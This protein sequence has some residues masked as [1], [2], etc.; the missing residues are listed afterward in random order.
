MFDAPIVTVDEERSQSWARLAICLVALVGFGVIVRTSDSVQPATVGPGFATILAYLTFGVIWHAFLTRYPRRFPLR[1]YVAMTADIGIMV[2]WMHLGGPFVTAY[3]PIFLWVIIG[4]GIRF[5]PRFLTIGLVMGAMGMGSLLVFNEY[6]VGHLSLGLGLLLGV[7]VLPVFFLTVLRRLQTVGRLE[8]ELARSRLADK[9]KDEFLASMSH[10]LRTP[11]NGVLGMAELLK[12]TDLDHEQREQVDVI[13]RSVNC[14]QNIINDILDYSR[15]SANRLSLEA[16]PFDLEQVLGDVHQLLGPTAGDKGIEVVFDYPVDAP[17]RVCGDPTRVRQIAFNLLGN[18]IKFTIEGTVKLSCRVREKGDRLAVT[19]AV[20]DTGVGIP[21]ER[22]G[23]IFDVFE[24]ADN[25]VTRQYGGSGLGLSISR[26]L[27]QLMDGDVSVDSTHG[28]GST[29]TASLMLSPS[30]HENVVEIVET[31]V[32]S[33][34][35]HELHALIVEDNAFNQLVTRKTLA[36]LG[37]TSDIAEDGSVSLE[38][39]DRRS[40]D[41]VLM[42]IRM[43]VMDGYEATRRI[44]ARDDDRVAVPIIALTAEASRSAQAQCR[45]VG[46]DGYL[47]KPLRHEKLAAAIEELVVCTA[48]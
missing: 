7:V 35:Q 13:T 6:W 23:A 28:E 20:S 1:R 27:A 15:L 5:G 14:L 29:F 41:L 38:M 26:Q 3:Y 19:L 31:H 21:E 33:L 42:D 43:P 9:A 16:V 17:R 45:S 4:N 34:S 32:E 37:I 39:L 30:L 44:R 2:F 24:Q 46:M 10:E 25:S 12:D 48:G 18:A 36:K 11:M 40:Y 22:L 47:A 8:L